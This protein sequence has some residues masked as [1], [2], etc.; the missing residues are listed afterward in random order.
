MRSTADWAM[1]WSGCSSSPTAVT[2]QVPFPLF[3]LY[4]AGFVAVFHWHQDVQVIHYDIKS[5][6]VLLDNLTKHVVRLP[7]TSLVWPFGSIMLQQA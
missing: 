7:S 4:S 3:T 5:S 6:N 2:K 1:F